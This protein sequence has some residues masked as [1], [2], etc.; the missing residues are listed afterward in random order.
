[1]R[2][3]FNIL[4]SV[5]L[6]VSCGSAKHVSGESNEV[7]M[8][9]GFT[10]VS[11]EANTHSTKNLVVDEKDGSGYTNIAEYISGRVPGLQVIDGKVYIRGGG[12]SSVNAGGSD[13]LV[14]F[15][16]VEVP[17]IMSI[18]PNEVHD[19]TVLTDSS[20]SLY[21]FR[22]IG[23]VIQITSK[24]AYAAKQKAREDAKRAREEARARRK[25]SGK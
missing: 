13:P 16:G 11:K 9:L 4:A 5:L 6:V 14:V 22:G 21:G 20:T 23:G 18:N 15:D 3:V 12:A 2:K 8:D 10:S 19:I 7:D 17:D 24:A 25:T 1:M